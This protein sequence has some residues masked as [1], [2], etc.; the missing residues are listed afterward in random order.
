[1]KV[2]RTIDS[3]CSQIYTIAKTSSE[4]PIERSSVAGGNRGGQR[5]VGEVLQ[6]AH[7]IGGI[8]FFGMQPP[9]RRTQHF[10]DERVFGAELMLELASQA[11]R[12]GRLG[13]RG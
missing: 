2:L 13:A 6:P 3:E 11:R 4:Y 7:A 5:G 8:D 1:V 10:K 9:A 12:K